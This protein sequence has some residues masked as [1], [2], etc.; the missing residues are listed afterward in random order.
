MLRPRVTVTSA[1]GGWALEPAPVQREAPGTNRYG[2]ILSLIVFFLTA[3]TAVTVVFVSTGG[4]SDSQPPTVARTDGIVVASDSSTA[5]ATPARTSVAQPEPTQ[6]STVTAAPAEST[7]RTVPPPSGSRVDQAAAVA[8]AAETPVEA[9]GDSAAVA[10]NST[11]DR[12][13]LGSGA[14]GV[15]DSRDLVEPADRIR[16]YIGLAAAQPLPSMFVYTIEEGDTLAN[17]A[18]RFGLD[19]ATIHFNNFDLYDPNLLVKGDTLRLPTVDGVI[20]TVKDGDSLSRLA[21]NFS[22]DAEATVAYPGN[23]LSSANQIRAGQTLVL[24]GGSASIPVP[25]RLSGGSQAVS[26]GW[27]MPRFG[28]PLAFDQISDPF[29]SPRNNRV[30][31]HTGVDFSAAAG[32]IVGA[33]AGGQVSFAGWD[34]SFGNWVEIDHGG[35]VRS[36]YAHLS[37]IWV[38]TGQWLGRGDFVGRVGNTGNSSGAHLHFE[39]IMQGTPVDPLAHLE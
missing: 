31:Y 13:E 32:T 6:A 17:I 38:V 16:D 34:A 4:R 10:A 20:Y 7:S 21:S 27:T 30:G 29:G 33:T 11:V 18:G 25:Q 39:I 9:P 35:G 28:W 15:N 3:I 19:E 24:V 23:G 36:R 2:E 14:V 12:L 5:T 22:A 26:A 1:L 37:E 8:P